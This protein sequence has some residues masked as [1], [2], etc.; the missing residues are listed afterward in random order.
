MF[1]F[2]VNWIFMILII[3]HKNP[4]FKKKG[5]I[6]AEYSIILSLSN[7]RRFACLQSKRD[8]LH[9]SITDT[10]IIRFNHFNKYYLSM[11]LNCPLIFTHVNIHYQVT[12]VIQ[13]YYCWFLTQLYIDI[14]APTFTNPEHTCRNLILL[15]CFAWNGPRITSRTLPS[16]WQC[17]EKS[18]LSK[19]IKANIYLLHYFEL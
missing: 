16:M 11:I 6:Y 13:S 14:A 18:I 3:I 2:S 7:K 8:N 4:V 5:R 9:I 19:Q 10:F 17:S 15:M 1:F 12:L